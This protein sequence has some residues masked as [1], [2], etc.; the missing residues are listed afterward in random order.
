MKPNT[1]DYAGLLPLLDELLDTPETDRAAW[2]ARLPDTYTASRP[3]L[4]RM[5]QASVH[6]AALPRV[7]N[8][9][10]A[11][12]SDAASLVRVEDLT[13]GERIGPYELI[14]ELGR[15]GMGRVWLANRA[16]GA[17]TRAVA[18]KLPLVNWAGHLGE[19]MQR[20]RDILAALEHPNIARFYDAGSDAQ[21]RPFMA[22]EYVEG[23][24][25][26]VFCR[27]NRLSIRARLLLVLKVA[28]TVAF[29]HSKLVVHQD[30]KPS[31]ILITA[32]GDVR[33]LDFGIAKL[34]GSEPAEGGVRGQLLTPRYASPEQ[35]RGDAIGTATDVYSLGVV[36][37]ELLTEVRAHQ[38]DR[39]RTGDLLRAASESANDP[40]LKRRLRGDLDAILKMAMQDRPGQRYA[41]LA[42]F[43][44]DI[45]CYLDGFPIHAREATFVY[46]ARKFIMRNRIPVG[47]GTLVIAAILAG[48]ALALWQANQA[49]VQAARA[50]AFAS[51]NRAVTEYLGILIEESAEDDRPLTVKQMLERSE[52][53]ALAEKRVNPSH[54]AAVL[55]MLAVQYHTLNQDAKAKEIID[56]A[57][58]LSRTAADRGLYSRVRCSQAMVMGGLGDRIA[59]RKIIAQVLASDEVG[60]E[61]V[62]HCHEIAAYIAVDLLDG[63]A[64]LRESL[65]AL[66][67]L[68]STSDPSPNAEASYLGEVASALQL[69]KRYAEAERYFQD[70]V[71]RFDELGRAGGAEAVSVSNDLGTMLTES[72]HPG[73]AL[74]VFDRT[75]AMLARHNSASPPP[76]FLIANRA[77][78]MEAMGMYREAMPVNRSCIER[79]QGV[80]NITGAAYCTLGLATDAL[81]LGEVDQAQR[82]FDEAKRLLAGDANTL[83][84]Y[85][86]LQF[87]VAAK[88]ELARGHLA[89]A[90]L[91]FDDMVRQGLGHQPFVTAMRGRGRLSLRE[92]RFEDALRDAQGALEI[93]QEESASSHSARIGLSWLQIAQI[94]AA[95]GDSLAARDAARQALEQFSD[96]VVPASPYVAAA[97]QFVSASAPPPRLLPPAH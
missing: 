61:E 27:E 67:M 7:P 53:L 38:D 95:Q 22:M 44:A 70:A 11:A 58:Q 77:A 25:I 52:G 48:A 10:S 87:L 72:G 49:R 80:S 12:I 45:E 79:A 28:K 64:A 19:R 50:L 68:R 34:I 47:A 23:R 88:I 35:M 24:P 75:F 73:R 94:H 83:R 69:Q 2:L 8:F 46:R 14:R 55:E 89:K 20:E 17:F 1:L 56:S 31:N 82:D 13:P 43:A 9:V 86:G 59:A 18:L 76:A 40:S 39:H 5:L 15:G 32:D 41:A 84:V 96:T 29:A 97:T 65:A 63:D 57:E 60:P 81:E 6:F 90:R 42:T 92:G 37:Y 85:S 54:R 78:A 33:L 93:S 3:H 30:L 26:D 66:Q 71:Q 21:G 91:L 74:Q 36:A 51:Q 4:A 62:A 16:D